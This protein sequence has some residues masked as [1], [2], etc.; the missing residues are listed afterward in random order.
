MALPR[1]P[2]SNRLRSAKHCPAAAWQFSRTSSRSCLRFI[3]Q[4]HSFIRRDCATEEDYFLRNTK[5]AF[6]LPSVVRISLFILCGL[7]LTFPA[8]F[9][10]EAAKYPDYPSE[11]P[12]QLHSATA[13]FNYVKRDV[14]IPM[15]DGVRLHTVIIIPKGAHDAPM[16]LT[17]TPY[18]ATDQ[19]SHAASS[20]LGPILEG[21]DN[22]TDVIVQGGY[23]RVVQ[24]VRG[25]YGSE[26][27]SS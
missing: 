10:Q 20:H 17:R 8:C 19:T 26:G 14:M 11:T 15:R 7:S 12:A 9:A 5:T 25:K 13:S 24:D 18:S 23:I 22:P 3:A 6:A 4:V 1:V 16:L 2:R 27:D 21:Y